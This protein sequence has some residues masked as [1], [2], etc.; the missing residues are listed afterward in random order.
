MTTEQREAINSQA[1]VDHLSRLADTA[2][3]Q[4]EQLKLIAKALLR[5]ADELHDFVQ[6]H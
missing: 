2:E 3:A 5:I 6:T 1:M 4:N